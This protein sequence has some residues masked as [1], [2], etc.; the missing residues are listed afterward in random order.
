[1]KIKTILFSLILLSGIGFV[2]TSKVSAQDAG[3]TAET[4]DTPR[5]GLFGTFRNRQD[6]PVESPKGFESPNPERT[7]E[8][9]ETPR[10][11]GIDKLEGERL[12]FC[13]NHQDE[14]N[15]RLTSLGS[16]V[17][18]ILGKFDAIA[19]RVEEFYT[20]KVVPTGKTVSNYDALLS[21]IKAKKDAVSTALSNSQSDINGF[22]CNTDN[23]KGQIRLFGTDMQIVHKALQD[24]RTSIKNLIV[25]VMSVVGT[26]ESSPVSSATP[27][28]T[29]TP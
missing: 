14:I 11:K 10:V 24:Y 7:F 4:T 27:V 6:G 20:T 18:N 15:T 5:P 22:S 9:R 29:A 26:G 8:P 3:S 19:A 17:A 25:A 13:E 1:M 23:P 21:D 16:L 2:F 28:A 12:Q